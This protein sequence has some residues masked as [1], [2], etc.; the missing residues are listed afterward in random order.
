MSERGP[1][2]NKKRAPE[3]NEEQKQFSSE[4]AIAASKKKYINIGKKLAKEG[5]DPENDRS[6]IMDYA[7]T[8]FDKVIRDAKRYAREKDDARKDKLKARISKNDEN[9]KR[10]LYGDDQSFKNVHVPGSK[11]KELAD[12]IALIDDVLKNIPENAPPRE[13]ETK[14]ERKSTSN[15]PRKEKPSN[16]KKE[17]SVA[18]PTVVLRRRRTSLSS[19]DIKAIQS[20]EVETTP[21]NDQSGADALAEPDEDVMRAPDDTEALKQ[22]EEEVEALSNGQVEDEAALSAHGESTAAIL[23]WADSQASLPPEI[24]AQV[25]ELRDPALGSRIATRTAAVDTLMRYRASVESP[26]AA[27]ASAA[28]QPDVAPSAPEGKQDWKSVL[29]WINAQPLSDEQ[30][31]KIADL[32]DRYTYAGGRE[33]KRD[34][35]QEARELQ[36]SLG[37][38][39]AAP[40][41]KPSTPPARVPAARRQPKVISAPITIGGD[42]DAARR[43]QEA[44]YEGFVHGETGKY[45]NATSDELDQKYTGYSEDELRQMPG[46]SD[47]IDRYDAIGRRLR[48]AID[49]KDVA[50]QQEAV[51]DLDAFMAEERARPMPRHIEAVPGTS[52]APLQPVQPQ[53]PEVI[54]GVQEAFDAYQESKTATATVEPPPGQDATPA[55]QKN[56]LRRKFDAVFGKSEKSKGGAGRA[57]QLQLDLDGRSQ[58][59]DTR[60]QGF[61]GSEKIK[62]FVEGYNNLSWKTKLGITGGLMIG[63]LLTA[64][65]MPA[66]AS[67]LGGIAGGQRILAGYGFS[68]NVRKK[69]DKRLTDKPDAA[70]SKWYGSLS[71]KEKNGA[72]LVLAG[73]YM[74]AT[75]A[76]FAGAAHE[77]K[78]LADTT[79]VT[80][81]VTEALGK[82]DWEKIKKG[83]AEGFGKF[84]WST[85]GT[86]VVPE[87]EIKGAPGKAAPTSPTGEASPAEIEAAREKLRSGGKVPS[88]PTMAHELETPTEGPSSKAPVIT[89]A[90]AEAH[91]VAS[92]KATKGKGYEYM[93]K[94][95]MR[96]LQVRTDFDIRTWPEGSDMRE[97]LQTDPKLLD[98]KIHEIATD[99]KFFKEGSG[100]SVLIKPGDVLSVDSKGDVWLNDKTILAPE[101]A[102]T[103]PPYHPTP[104]APIAAAEM[105]VHDAVPTPGAEATADVPDTRVGMASDEAVPL[106]RSAEGPVEAPPKPPR[107]GTGEMPPA[108][109]E[110]NFHVNRF[111]V[112]VDLDNPHI[113]LTP[114]G[115]MAV[116]GG[117]PKA[118]EVFVRA[119]LAKHPESQI[120]GA[121]NTE[122]MQIVWRMVGKDVGYDAPRGLMS[123]LK[124]PPRLSQ[125]KEM[126]V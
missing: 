52:P 47:L 46:Y 43:V 109:A 108:N 17:S 34:V 103:T 90:P 105:A 23:A 113:Y 94:S 48:A 3:A 88:V 50:A 84:S 119:F 73:G 101:G 1:K 123:L 79:G 56:W 4:R 45:F 71:D 21:G 49:A 64:G 11:K 30:K 104:K 55:E 110:R 24:Q 86:Q 70:F 89:E 15:Q 37:G 42:P 9:L 75:S 96:E 85:D 117:N 39:K 67:V 58:Q 95:L 29:K 53:T 99:N 59:L 76:L 91:E 106:T 22:A 102:K 44:E 93:L 111:L 112:P 63:G 121:N 40:K 7:T 120:L 19:E 36:E 6:Q 115:E 118:Q 82:I 10:V 126:I 38:A 51:K 65:A 66:L 80:D 92:V 74:L 13:P 62:R 124:G 68:L 81:K 26:K 116:Y 61:K 31:A 69:L 27:D 33:E 5:F 35:L 107:E 100:R 87:S 18:E 20:Q 41:A 125:L 78:D 28:T 60:T 2:S 77:L 8:Q 98:Q 25:D 97:L 83:L 114:K 57:E 72:S 16:T 32:Q 122:T 14:K 12:R 54:D